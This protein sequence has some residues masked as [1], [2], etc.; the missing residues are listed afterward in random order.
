MSMDQSACSD[1]MCVLTPDLSPI[2]NELVSQDGWNEESAVTLFVTMEG[3]VGMR[4]LVMMH[5]INLWRLSGGPAIS[6][7]I[8]AVAGFFALVQVSAYTWS[9]LR[10][11]FLD[12]AYRPYSIRELG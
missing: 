1:A 8:G 7:A 3:Q 11:H 2:L 10:A 9:I 12:V 6:L 4:P 5:D